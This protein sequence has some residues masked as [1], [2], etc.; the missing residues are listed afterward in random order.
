MTEFKKVIDF[1]G[2]QVYSITSKTITIPNNFQYVTKVI[3]NEKVVTDIEDLDTFDYELLQQGY[4]FIFCRPN[5]KIPKI[6]FGYEDFKPSP[7]KSSNHNKYFKEDPKK[8]I[9]IEFNPK[10]NA[11]PVFS[12]E[13]AFAFTP[14]ELNN[15]KPTE[16][17]KTIINNQTNK[18]PLDWYNNIKNYCP[19]IHYKKE[20]SKKDFEYTPKKTDL[21]LTYDIRCANDIDILLTIEEKFMNLTSPIIIYEDISNKYKVVKEFCSKNK[22][23]FDEGELNNIKFIKLKYSDYMKV[24]TLKTNIGHLLC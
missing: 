11:N 24:T 16:I 13:S 9:I 18:T 20:I 14:D 7:I 15:S 3:E 17:L 12:K 6:N 1:P 21:M 5:V 19:E 10:M 2:W 23:S 8:P 22:I 4:G